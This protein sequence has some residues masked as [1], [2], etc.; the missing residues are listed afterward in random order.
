MSKTKSPK[1][2][3]SSP[4]LTAKEPTKQE[5]QRHMEETRESLAHTVEQLKDTVTTQVETV[6]E[7]VSGVL[8][9]RQ[10]FQNE[11]LVWSLG[12]LSAGF[13]LGYTLGFAHQ[14]THGSKSRSKVAAFAD[15]IVDELSTVGQSFL[16][17]ALTTK[18]KELF[19][20]DFS[21]LLE[22][23]AGAKKQ[24]KRTTRP[25]KLAAKSASRKTAK[26]R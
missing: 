11:P 5:L 2:A 4:P 7:S 24:S 15:G 10:Q 14:T 22:E 21:E 13:A 20:F 1:A 8:D 17:P 26:K 6:K 12:A 18:I 16:M 25:K 3:E 23:L 19:G 9:F